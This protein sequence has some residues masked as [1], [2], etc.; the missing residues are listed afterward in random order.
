MTTMSSR[1]ATLGLGFALTVLGASSPAEAT[2]ITS[3]VVVSNGTTYNAANVGW[4]FPVTLATGQDLVLTQDF[5]GVANTTTSYDFD[6]SDD[7]VAPAP[8]FPT[9]AVTADGVT[10]TF[11]DAFQV[12]NVKNK[13]SVGLD[14]NEAQNYG[15]ALIGPGYQLFLGYADNVHPG[16]C[17]DYAT[18]IG[19]LGSGTCFPSPF[20]SASFFQG[21]GGIDPNLPQTNP[22][23]C[24]NDG[25][26]T[27]Y[28]AA[29]LRIVA[30][31]V[32]EPAT[33]TLFATGLA[34][35]IARRRSHVR[36][37]RETKTALG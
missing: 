33:M 5:Q 10:T 32:P 2:T 8:A 12:L 18:S 17:G 1:L 6:T 11:T 34:G 14:L 25:S 19:L 9:I 28:D 23:H 24:A 4:T 16:V 30:T 20:A 13:G 36:K 31:N 27:C 22:F 26:A 7:A 15:A 3:V 21:R 37:A 29:V 35:L